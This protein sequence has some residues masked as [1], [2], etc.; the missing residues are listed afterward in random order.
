MEDVIALQRAA[1]AEHIR[2]E[3]AGDCPAV[4]ETFVQDPEA[5]WDFVPAETMF[6]GPEGIAR[7][8]RAFV[9]AVPDLQVEVLSEYDV[10]G[11][12]IRE[13]LITGTHRGE[14]AGIEPTGQKVRCRL[15][16]FFLFGS[17]PRGIVMERGYFDHDTIFRQ[18]RGEAA[19]SQGSE[20]RSAG[21][22]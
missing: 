3:N 13:V 14:Y 20:N 11:C 5:R 10:P 21:R 8:Y 22:T 9:A 15:A 2:G 19:A 18:M 7:F 12:S 17:N 6:K 1:V 16:C 4:Y